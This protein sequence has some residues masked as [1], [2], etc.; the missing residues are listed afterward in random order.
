MQNYKC[1]RCGNTIMLGKFKGEVCPLD[2]GTLVLASSCAN[3]SYNTSPV[4]H[5][6]SDTKATKNQ[7]LLNE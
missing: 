1:K 5:A 7:V 2:Q 4:E 3:Q 6:N